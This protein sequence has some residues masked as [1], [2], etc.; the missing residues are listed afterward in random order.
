MAKFQLLN[1]AVDDLTEIWNYTFDEWS[2]RQADKYYKTLIDT[3]SELARNPRLGKSYQTISSGL[4]GFKSGEHII[5]YLIL[6]EKEIEV[7]RIL[8]GSMDLKTRF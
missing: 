3:C 2:E 8:N 5:F 7:V 6:A 4:V 1:R